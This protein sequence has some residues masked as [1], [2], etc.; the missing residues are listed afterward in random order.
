[1][2]ST[3]GVAGCDRPHSGRGYCDTHI[4]RVRKYGDPFAHVPIGARHNVPLTREPGLFGRYWFLSAEGY[5][6]AQWPEHPIANPSG[7]ISQ[8][9]A[10]LYAAIGSGEHPCDEC[11]QMLTWRI[12]EADHRN[13]KRDDNRPENLRPLCKPCNI[14]DAK[15]RALRDREAG[16]V[17]VEAAFVLPILLVIILGGIWLGLFAFQ[18]SRT[19]H[20]AEQ[21]A[22]AGAQ[23]EEGA[24][25]C[26]IALEAAASVLTAPVTSES[27]S[28]TDG[29]VTVTLS[30]HLPPFP[31]T[32]FIH[33]GNYSGTGSAIIREGTMSGTP[34]PSE[35]GNAP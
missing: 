15:R 4:Q 23:A 30:G 31:I 18:V 22:I 9:R 33:D 19:V 1:M 29:L 5:F 21:G 17:L 34:P 16:I 8:Q 35:E 11:G 12:I 24:G 20:A 32:E 13:G 6:M 28:E 26:D 2:R 3:C 7:S 10:V 14:R 27:C 25:R